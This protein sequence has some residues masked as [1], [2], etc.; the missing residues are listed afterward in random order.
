MIQ[1]FIEL[2]QGY[3]DLYELIEIAET[4]SH[5]LLHML[6]FDTKIK[7]RVMSSLVVVLKPAEEGKFMPLYI[8]REGIPQPEI[9]PN[10]RYKLFE[11]TANKLGK[12]IIPLEIKP[13]STFQETEL[14]F[15]YVIGLLRMNNFIPPLQ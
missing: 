13:S 14:Y 12:N 2:G 10:Q 4:N 11:A 3:S 15:Q 9:T 5:R 8:C 1:R 7:D 6:R